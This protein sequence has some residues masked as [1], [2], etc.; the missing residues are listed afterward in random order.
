MFGW[1]AGDHHVLRDGLEKPAISEL[2]FGETK[3][4][5]AVKNHEGMKSYCA[6]RFILRKTWLR[7]GDDVLDRKR[8]RGQHHSAANQEDN[9]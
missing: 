2:P 7:Q 3:K 6:C 9:E 4:E 8:E 5:N 1:S